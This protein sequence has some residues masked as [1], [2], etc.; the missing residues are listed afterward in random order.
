[1]AIIMGNTGEI[2][3]PHLILSQFKTFNTTSAAF[4][5]VA[6]R[7]PNFSRQHLGSF[8]SSTRNR[9]TYKHEFRINDDGVKEYR[10]TK[11][12]KK[13]RGRGITVS[14]FSKP[15]NAAPSQIN[16]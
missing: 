12:H 1:M 5:A 14:R 13:N 6:A 3:V 9:A 4:E 10:I 2:N 15:K 11:I 7:V 8:I 16:F